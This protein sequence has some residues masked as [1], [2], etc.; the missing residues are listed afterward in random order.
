VTTLK[1]VRLRDVG[2]ADIIALMNHPGVRRHMPLSSDRFGPAEC[3]EFVAAKEAMWEEH[4]YGPWAFLIDSAFAG[5]GGLQPED[6]DADLGLVLHPAYWGH[7]KMIYERVI[8]WAFDDLGLESVTILLP[9]TRGGAHAIR[10][11][12][13]VPDGETTLS[14]ERFLRYRL[15]RV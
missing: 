9:P 3:A 11:L 13:F 8:A 1:L 5:W 15:R 4:G 2:A 10:R 7:G 6:G 12:G 14:G